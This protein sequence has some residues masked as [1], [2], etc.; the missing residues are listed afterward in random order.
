MKVLVGFFKF[1]KKRMIFASVYHL[2]IV[3]VAVLMSWR[4]VVHGTRDDPISPRTS[5]ETTRSSVSIH[6]FWFLFSSTSSLF[7]NR[8]IF[9]FVILFLILFKRM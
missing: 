5:P 3:F 9:T 7:S 4:L 6:P 8:S 1:A 2:F